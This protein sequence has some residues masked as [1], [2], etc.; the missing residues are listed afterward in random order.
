MRDEKRPQQV[1]RLLPYRTLREVGDQDAPIVHR[2]GEIEF[3]SDLI[4]D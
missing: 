4:E 1:R 2:V 3:W